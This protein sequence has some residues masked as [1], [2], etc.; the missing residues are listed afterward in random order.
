[1][2]KNNIL[3]TGGSGF[4]G[5]QVVHELAKQGHS[6]TVVDREIKH[7]D[8]PAT[9]YEM[10]YETYFKSMMKFEGHTFDTV[11]HLAA[12]HLVGRSVLE[13]S[14]F[15]ENNVVKM[16]HMLDAMVDHGIKNIIFSSSGGIY[17]RQGS[18]GN[19]LDESLYADSENT[20]ASTKIAG[21]LL[22]KDYAKA[23]GLNYVIF[24]YFNAGGADPD[25]RFGYVQRPA[26]H[27]IPILCN[28]I[29]RGE[30]FTING[31]D[32][33]TKD[34]TCVRDYVHVADIAS[35]HTR[36]IKY[37]NKGNSDIFNLGGQ[38]GG[39]S[40]KELIDLTGKVVGKDPIIEYGPRRDG[41]PAMLIANISKA[42]QLLKW[43][44]KYSIEDIITHAWN[45]ENKFETSK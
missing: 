14:E 2:K 21:E 44:P 38:A 18:N 8:V 30:T 27:I 20:Y 28:K 45:W 32:Y 34:R 6:L 35:A 23:Y 9:V 5:N 10:D 24:R 29:L 16:K 37:I 19:L 12:D 4:I 13:P 42:K 3:I 40:I 31:N 36:A 17:G 11:V 41:D 25:N 7:D 22:I 43:T 26:S 33:L 1:M 39:V 15:Y